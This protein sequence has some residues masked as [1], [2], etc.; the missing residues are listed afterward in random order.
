VFQ[1][2]FAL[3]ILWGVVLAFTI[4]NRSSIQQPY[5]SIMVAALCGVGAITRI[6]GYPEIG[7]TIEVSGIMLI[8]YRFYLYQKWKTSRTW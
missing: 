8:A 2:S 3:P 4:I 1:L 5:F 7:T 6:S